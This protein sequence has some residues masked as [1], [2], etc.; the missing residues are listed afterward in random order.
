MRRDPVKERTADRAGNGCNLPGRGDPADRIGKIVPRH[1]V[2]D[3]AGRGRAVEG[4]RGAKQGEDGEDQHG[5]K[6]LVQDEVE[7][8]GGAAEEYQRAAAHHQPPAEPVG[9]VAGYENKRHSGEELNE[10]DPA[11]QRRV[12]R[13]V[14]H[15]P[16]DGD[17][18]ELEAEGGEK[19]REQVTA[20]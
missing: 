5:F 18:D 4:P 7:N 13:H 11:Q 15:L 14:I 12:A 3:E 6:P 8:R 2:D 1:D 19:A 17:R 20:V 16:G 10:P 9:G